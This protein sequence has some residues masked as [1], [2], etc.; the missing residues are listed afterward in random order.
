M[1]KLLKYSVLKYIPSPLS[2]ER[3]V[4]GIIFHE[5]ESD[6]REFRLRQYLSPLSQLD[7]EIDI[8][9][10]EKLLRG[11]KEEVESKTLSKPFDIE[12]FIRFYLNAYRFEGTKTVKYEV[13]DESIESITQ[14]Y[15]GLDHKQ[16]KD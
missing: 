11:I 4:L 10:V 8:G 15:L 16:S 9:L 6:Y 3:F 2:S 12:E 5:E 7:A 13:L 14:F 1:D